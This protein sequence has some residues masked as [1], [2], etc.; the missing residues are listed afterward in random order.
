MGKSVTLLFQRSGSSKR[1]FV[2]TKSASSAVEILRLRS[3]GAHS[4]ASCQKQDASRNEKSGAFH[5]CEGTA[6]EPVAKNGVL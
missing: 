5:D 1:H 2:R 3:S 6:Q 4:A